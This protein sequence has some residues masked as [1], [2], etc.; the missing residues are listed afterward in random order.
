MKIRF[1][2]SPKGRGYKIGDEIEFAGR[3]EEEYARKYVK[4]GWAVDI[5]PKVSESTIATTE[6]DEAA[7]AAQ[8]EADRLQAEADKLAARRDTKIPAKWAD[9]PWTDLRALASGLT[10]DPVK[11]KADAAAVIEAELK[12]RAA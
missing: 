10:D 2:E 1:V 3:I 4:R 7:A 8:A 6:A 12:H 5:S 9:L 11:S